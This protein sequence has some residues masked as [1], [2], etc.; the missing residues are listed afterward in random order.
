MLYVHIHSIHKLH[1]D[2]YY[3]F[4]MLPNTYNAICKFN[5]SLMSLIQSER[6]QVPDN[7]DRYSIS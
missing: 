3:K 6:S 4:N 1:R 7:A 2:Y 5:C